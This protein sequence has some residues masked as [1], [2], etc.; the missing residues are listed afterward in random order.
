MLN[1]LI[2]LSGEVTGGMSVLFTDKVSGTH[3]I[4]HHCTFINN[5]SS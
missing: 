1:W 2:W 3:L 5:T 4:V